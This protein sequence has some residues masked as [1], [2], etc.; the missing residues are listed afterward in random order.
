MRL[1]PNESQYV[2]TT[3]LSQG[4]VRKAQILAA[5]RNRQVEI[6]KLREQLASLESLEQSTRRPSGRGRSGR[7][8]KAV[9][10]SQPRHR[11][12]PMSAK[13]RRLRQQQGRYMSFVR[14]LKP[15]EKARVRSVREKDGMRAAIRLA[16]SLAKKSS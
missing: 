8:G 16:S 9:G 3:L 12:R 10:S 11:R 14:G 4:R 1:T 2:L 7:A 13:V 5:L 15:V 6:R